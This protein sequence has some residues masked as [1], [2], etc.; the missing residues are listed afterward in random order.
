MEKSSNFTLNYNLFEG[1]NVSYTG[2]GFH[3][4][5]VKNGIIFKNTLIK[6]KSLSHGGGYAILRSSNVTLI[7]NKILNN[8]IELIIWE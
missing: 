2:G 4:S 3:L 7:D 5:E 8:F 6:N 1:N